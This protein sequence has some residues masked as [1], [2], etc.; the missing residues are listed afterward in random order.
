MPSKVLPPLSL[1]IVLLTLSWTANIVADSE[2][3]WYQRLVGEQPQLASQLEKL[4]PVGLAGGRRLAQSCY[5]TRSDSLGP[6]F[7]AAAPS[8]KLGF[9]PAS[10]SVRSLRNISVTIQLYDG[11]T[12]KP[13][14]NG[15]GNLD[16]WLADNAGKYDNAKKSNGACSTCKC[17]AKLQVTRLTN[18][19]LA[20][21]RYTTLFPASYG[22]TAASCFRPAHIHH[23]FQV[24]GYRPLT[25]QLYFNGDKY[26]GAK[27]CGCPSCG[28]GNSALQVTLD[29]QNRA[30]WKVYLIPITIPTLKLIPKPTP[31]RRKSLY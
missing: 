2:P 13:I 31:A 17:R 7:L 26:L 4:L 27:D 8:Y 19:G 12:N 3:G 11:C 16:I 30:T 29:K 15:G 18:N 21:F 14:K 28:S 9:C 10:P 5:A 20:G 22:N 6:Y 25:T 24:S 23:T 1:L